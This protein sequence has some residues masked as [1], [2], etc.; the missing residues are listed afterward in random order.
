MPHVIFL[1]GL[2]CFFHRTPAKDSCISSEF[3]LKGDFVLG[4]LFELHS[5]I[6]HPAH[7]FPVVLEC[8]AFKF[9]T[10]GYQMLQVMR[11]AVEEINN[12]TSILPDVSLGY[13]IFDHCSEIHNFPSVFEF[14]SKEGAFE[15]HANFK[16][17]QPKVVS[18]IGPFGSS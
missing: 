8:D 9:L 1:F 16:D 13:E 5:V 17:Y 11:F 2:M 10:A 14:L 6:N 18:V 12:S 7:D 3:V 4:G 15:I